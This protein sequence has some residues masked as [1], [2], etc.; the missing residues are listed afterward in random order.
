MG[1]L[2]N[3]FG[4]ILSYVE[5]YQKWISG[6][7]EINIMVKILMMMFQRGMRENDMGKTMLQSMLALFLFWTVFSGGME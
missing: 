1:K 3:G 7:D 5:I 2:S 6:S 4:W